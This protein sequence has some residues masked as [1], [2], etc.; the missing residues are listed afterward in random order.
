MSNSATDAL[1]EARAA[2]E[3]VRDS[4]ERRAAEHQRARAIEVAADREFAS[5]VRLA[6]EA[7]VPYAALM[8][9]T[10]LSRARIDQIRRGTR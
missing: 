2:L 4:H 5:A 9:V 3:A 6:R 1:A 7:R 8:E 10:G